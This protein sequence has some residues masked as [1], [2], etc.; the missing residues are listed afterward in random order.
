MYWIKGAHA[1]K[2]ERV[3]GREQEFNGYVISADDCCYPTLLSPYTTNR[4]Y[5]RCEKLPI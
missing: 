4:W 2:A 1:R 3:A 5:L